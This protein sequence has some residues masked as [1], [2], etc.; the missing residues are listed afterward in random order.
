MC[1]Y[2]NLKEVYFYQKLK[3]NKVKC[4][5]CPHYCIISPNQTGICRV[6]KNIDGSLFA[7]NYGKVAA[8][9]IDPIEKKPLYHFYPGQDILSIGSY[10]CNLKCDFC[11]NYTIAH[12]E[13]NGTYTESEKIADIACREENNIGIAYTYNEPFMWY[14]FVKDSAQ[15]VK[16]K[17]KKNVMVTNG[18]INEESLKEL[19]PFIDAMNIDLKAFSDEFYK[20]I[21]KGAV[22]PV[23][24]TIKRAVKYCHVE[25]TTLLIDNLNT[26]EKEIDALS[27]WI[28]SIDRDIPLHLTRYYPAYKMNIPPTSIEKIKKL[29]DIAQNY[30]NYVYIGNVV[31]IDRN[32]Y[33]PQCSALLINRETKVVAQNIKSS[34]CTNCGRKVSITI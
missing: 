13:P 15:M 30:L 25:V 24:K 12:G 23:L 11:Q 4:E 9:N 34:K 26:S 20:D 33:C 32:T 28:A 27:R 29:K 3:D 17:G 18:Y 14:E 22:R 1:L 31:G 21:C 10:G 6:R 5:V 16:K 8:F 2:Q 7:L 19:L